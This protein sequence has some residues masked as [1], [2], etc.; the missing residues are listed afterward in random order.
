[1]KKKCLNCGHINQSNNGS[2]NFC[3]ACGQPL[4]QDEAESNDFEYNFGANNQSGANNYNNNAYYNGYNAN[5]NYN[6]KNT[7][8]NY[9]QNVV[10][11]DIKTKSAPTTLNKMK[12]EVFVAN[13]F[14]LIFFL[15][16]AIF[17]LFS[18]EDFQIMQEELPN[19]E[20]QQPALAEVGRQLIGIYYWSI[21]LVAA[22]CLLTIVGIVFNAILKSVRFPVQESKV[23]GRYKVLAVLM[24][25]VALLSIGYLAIE[26]KSVF[27]TY[28]SETEMDVNA[29][30]IGALIADI[31]VAI[32]SLISTV[33]SIVI[34]TNKVER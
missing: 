10:T 16:R 25:V 27:I 1:M 9:A 2:L 5:V 22:C 30:L 19:L 11:P 8:G 3:E 17:L 34:A 15:I 21:G 13:I 6:A 33:Y 23:S 4:P 20:I 12:K 32:V 24:L 29:S 31:V 7:F 28:T 26:I 14:L 18:A